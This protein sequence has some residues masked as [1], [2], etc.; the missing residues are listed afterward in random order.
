MTGIAVDFIHYPTT[1]Y[2]HTKR[3]L[4]SHPTPTNVFIRA[5]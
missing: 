4:T 5:H 3:S 2:S 1:Y